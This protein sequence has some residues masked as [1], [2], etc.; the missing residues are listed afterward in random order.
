EDTDDALL[1]ARFGDTDDLRAFAARFGPAA[2]QRATDT[3]GNTLLH[4]AAANGHTDVLTYLLPLLPHPHPALLAQNAAGSTP[5]HWAALNAHLPA[6][7][8]L[9]RFPRGP[10]AA[11]VDARDA[12]GR[13]ALAHAEEGGWEEGARW[14]VG[15]MR[16]EG[17]GGAEGEGEGAEGLE[18]QEIEVEIE[19]ADGGIARLSLAQ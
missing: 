14:L 18:G 9:V 3:N 1:A 10:G 12:A 17:D 2:L 11:L 7:Q 13:S 16:I 5:L 6:L 8:A 19:D 4:M 15:V